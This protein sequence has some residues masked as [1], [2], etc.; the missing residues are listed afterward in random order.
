MK[1]RILHIY[2][3]MSAIVFALFM[4]TVFASTTFATQLDARHADNGLS[5]TDCHGETA[6]REAVSMLKCLECH[7][8][9][10]LADNTAETKPTN[11]HRNR[12]YNTEADCNLC[13]HQ[14]KPSD[15]VCLPCHA[16]FDFVVP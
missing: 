15:N 10:E 2:T 14:H 9:A 8:T 7:D 13:H 1:I 11:P 6:K 16:R 3:F 12:H 5:C 4:S